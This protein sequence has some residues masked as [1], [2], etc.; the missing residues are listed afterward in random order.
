MLLRGVPSC[1]GSLCLASHQL[2]IRLLCRQLGRP[3]SALLLQRSMCPSRLGVARLHRLLSGS[4]DGLHAI[5][6]ACQRVRMRRRPL[7]LGQHGA[8]FGLQAA[9]H[10][11][12]A[13]HVE[14][15]EGG[16]HVVNTRW[17]A[18]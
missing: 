15:C 18:L 14:L 13:P 8:V 17:C 3:S 9:D 11:L 10:V 5:G 12:V 1:T 6:L 16:P 2:R 7:R 4:L